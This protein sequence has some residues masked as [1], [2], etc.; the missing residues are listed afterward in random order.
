MGK[1]E[2]QL[3]WVILLAL[4]MSGCELVIFAHAIACPPCGKRTNVSP[5]GEVE[6]HNDTDWTI[7]EE[8]PG[9]P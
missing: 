9:K 1:R 6:S 4:S 8:P 5:P 2:I 7:I 3:S